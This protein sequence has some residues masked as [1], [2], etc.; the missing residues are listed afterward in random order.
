MKFQL[1]ILFAGLMATTNAALSF[2]VKNLCKYPVTP[3]S[4]TPG[5]K[6]SVSKIAIGATINNLVVSSTNGM[7]YFQGDGVGNAAANV[8]TG[9][10]WEW[11]SSAQFSYDISNVNGYNM[12]MSVVVTNG[13]AA[14]CDAI[15]CLAF[16]CPTPLYYTTSNGISVSHCPTPNKESGTTTYA[17]EMLSKCPQ[18]YG[19]SQQVGGTHGCRI[20]AP[21][22]MI[23]LCG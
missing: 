17:K 20:A 12:P 18:A 6:P 7:M 11:D 4:N 3:F 16:K 10:L 2:S 9:T 13:A 14:K 19:W 21:Q 15:S 5:V 1:A 8:N 23:T 22:V